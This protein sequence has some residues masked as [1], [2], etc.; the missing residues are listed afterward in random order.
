MRWE[1]IEGL[2]AEEWHDRSLADISLHDLQEVETQYSFM[3]IS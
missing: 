3:D 1:A 2:W